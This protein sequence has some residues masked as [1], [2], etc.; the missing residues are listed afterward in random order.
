[1]SRCS[2]QT[3]VSLKSLFPKAQIVGASDIECRSCNANPEVI[4][5]DGVIV[6]GLHES[7]DL[8]REVI[9]GVQ[10]GAQAVLTERF[11][12]S[13]VPQCIV[14]D[15]NEAYAT[16]CNAL[17]DYPSRKLLTIGVM[18]THG[19]TIASLLTSAMIKH[20]AGRVSYSTSLGA[21]NGSQTGMRVDSNC[22][23]HALTQLI[24]QAYEN[25]APAVIVELTDEM[26]CSKAA[27]GVEFDVILVTSL[28]QS[29]RCDKLRA[30]G[31]ENAMQRVT[32]QLKK[33]GVIVYNADDARLN[34]WIERHQPFSIGYG[35]DAA[36]DV[37]ASR[38]F[39]ENGEQSMMVQ[40][41]RSIAPITTKLI[42]DHSAR[43]ILGAVAIGYALGL[44]IDEIVAGVERLQRIPGRL[45]KVKA[46]QQNIFIDLADQADR[47]AVSLHALQRQNGAPIVC[48]AEVPEAS[49]PDQLMAYGRV[50]EKA[51]SKVILT[52]SRAT[53]SSGQKAIWQ[54][55]DGCSDPAAVQIVPNR[56]IAIELAMR[57]A[58]PGDQI[59][60]AG[61]GC[62][63][64]LNNQTKSPCSDLDVVDAVLR[65]ENERTVQNN[66][67]EAAPAL[68]IFGAA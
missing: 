56:E 21:C 20:V 38:L 67:V 49:T 40:V 11:L 27:S 44:E 16:L 36:C 3:V 24:S 37:M 52:Q 6:V 7:H 1:M 23:A 8:V 33:H 51:A 59:L 60:L 46:A 57:S 63:R 45:Q 10:N 32:N 68:R 22:D 28:R 39:S 50:L 65:A 47:L 54:V 66:A 55:L 15:V 12:P 14:P 18:G 42:G 29:Q 48:V 25:G 43:H 5:R 34:R 53:I 19:K 30:R 64:W 58:R 35:L 13:P 31:V 2:S 9:D 26:L 61:W 41:G 62:T 4:E 17:S